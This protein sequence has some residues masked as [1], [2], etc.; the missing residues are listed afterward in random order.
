MSGR[1]FRPI[2]RAL[3]VALAACEGKNSPPPPPVPAAI[4]VDLPSRTC[5]EG[6]SIAVMTTVLD[7]DGGIMALKPTLTIDPPSILEVD[8]STLRCAKEGAARIRA[9]L[10]AAEAVESITVASPL[11][12]RWRREDDDKAG[13]ELEVVQV[14]EQLNAHVVRAPT[15][16]ALPAIKKVYPNSA[17]NILSCVQKV[18][19]PGQKNGRR[20]RASD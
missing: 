12:G 17:S 5:R 14:G 2:L 4:K 18:W 3:F 15:D 20:S 7:G 11:I 6:T 1:T 10:G 19:P 13:L 8:G 9:S 16:A